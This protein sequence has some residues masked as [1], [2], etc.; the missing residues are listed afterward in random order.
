MKKFW[1]PTLQLIVSGVITS[2]VLGGW[3]LV[4]KEVSFHHQVNERLS[5][6]ESKLGINPNEK[7]TH[8]AI[9]N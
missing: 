2:A 4:S 6:I 1:L 8:V 7:E 5:A 9:R 3:N